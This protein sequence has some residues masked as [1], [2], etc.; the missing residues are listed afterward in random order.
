[1]KPIATALSILGLVG[2]VATLAPA[3]ASAQQV[4]TIIDLTPELT[5]GE[6]AAFAADVGSALRFRQLGDARTLGRG[7]VDVSVEFASAPIGNANRSIS[8]PRIVGRFGVSDRVDVGAWGGLNSSARYG[9]AGADLKILLLQQ[10]SAWPVT[11]SIRPSVTTLIGP[12]EVFAA[13]AG[14]DLTVS[15]AIGPVAPY[16]GVASTA[17][18]AIERSTKVDL[19]PA[20]AEG[21]V[22]YAGLAFRWRTMVMA[23]EVEKGTRVSYAFRIGTRF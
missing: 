23:A 19:D 21:S 20:T 15:R 10:G 2:L 5:N 12:S 18:L 16:A 22:A 17:S 6:F 9:L 7:D 3:P 8:F 11:F 1:M 13:G 14:L 4:G